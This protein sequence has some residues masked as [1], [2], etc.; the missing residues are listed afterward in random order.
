MPRKTEEELYRRAKELAE[1]ENVLRAKGMQKIAGVDEAGRGPPA[2]A[3]YSAAGILPSNTMILGM[4]DS[5][6]VHSS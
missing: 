3:G 6:E 4:D 5:K 2:G 1:Y